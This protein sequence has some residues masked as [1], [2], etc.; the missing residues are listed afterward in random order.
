MFSYL[1][2]K[3]T[4]K[5][6]VFTKLIFVFP[7]GWVKKTN[8]Q[9]HREQLT[10]EILNSEASNWTKS[11]Y[12]V[13]NSLHHQTRT[14]IWT[15]GKNLTRYVYSR[16]L[17]FI[18]YDVI[19]KTRW[20]CFCDCSYTTGSR[21]AV[22]PVSSANRQTGGRKR[23]SQKRRD[24]AR[25][26]SARAFKHGT[27]EHQLWTLTLTPSCLCTVISSEVLFFSAWFWIANLFHLTLAC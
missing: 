24:C 16:L 14:C 23:I 19:F 9:F 3:I 13:W 20:M 4:F 21:G 10:T 8:Q 6:L 18:I 1:C 26:C 2:R 5:Q 25:C 7:F 11:K 22:S 15:S 12:Y 27:L 17:R